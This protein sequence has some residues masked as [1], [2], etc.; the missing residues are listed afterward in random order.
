MEV[1]FAKKE[2]FSVIGK[3]GSTN[4]GGNFIEKLWASF[5][6]EFQ[7]V[8]K[9]AKKDNKGRVLGIWG[10][11]SSMDS[12]FSPWEDNYG[13]GLYL[14]GVEVEDSAVAPLGWTRWK[15]PTFN[16]A[17]VKVEDNYSEVFRYMIGEYLPN[18]KLNLVGAIQEYYCVEENMQ[19]YLFFPV[20]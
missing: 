6:Q 11:M 14:A 16:Y 1:K 3:L 4:E 10:A 19:L 18:N 5:N 15:I 12:S 2:S 17:Y 9:Y 13:K 7:K 20:D 8:L